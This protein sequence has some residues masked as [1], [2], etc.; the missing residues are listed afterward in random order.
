[1]N[2]MLQYSAAFCILAFSGLCVAFGGERPIPMPPAEF[3]HTTDS[4]ELQR[5]LD[6]VRG[7]YLAPGERPARWSSPA[8]PSEIDNRWEERMHRLESLRARLQADYGRSTGIIVLPLGSDTIPEEEPGKFWLATNSISTITSNAVPY[9]VLLVTTNYG[10]RPD[11]MTTPIMPSEERIAAARQYRQSI[12]D[13]DQRVGRNQSV[14]ERYAFLRERAPNLKEGMT[15]HEIVD[16]M[17]PPDQVLAYRPMEGVQNGFVLTPVMVEELAGDKGE[18]QMIFT[19]RSSFDP[20]VGKLG[21]VGYESL[22]VQ[23]D[24]SG[25]TASW[26]WLD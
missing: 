26:D 19:P 23:F 22:A 13:E 12:R 9:R 15:V 1:M 16:L 17:G 20:F 8:T 21:R 4:P 24:K 3:E 14:A 2:H 25:R 10:P 5:L 18:A 7:K 6:H 11:F